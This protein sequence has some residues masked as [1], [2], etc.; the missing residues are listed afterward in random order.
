MSLIQAFDDAMA[1][2]LDVDMPK[3]ERLK[4]WSHE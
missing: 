3:V 1:D 4:C 2:P